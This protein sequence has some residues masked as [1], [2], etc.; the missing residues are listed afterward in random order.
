METVRGEWA[1]GSSAGGSRN[2]LDLFATNPQFLLELYEAGEFSHNA[3]F[4]LILTVPSR[5]L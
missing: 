4:V 1:V 2:N 5:A 3:F